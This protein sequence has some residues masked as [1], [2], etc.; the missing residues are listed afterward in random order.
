MV[1]KTR[2]RVI[3]QGSRFCCQCGTNLLQNGLHCQRLFLFRVGLAFPLHGLLMTACVEGEEGWSVW[4]SAGGLF[5]LAATWCCSNL[6]SASE[7]L[8]P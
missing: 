6:C 7:E 2:R 8:C 5:F 1:D 3:K 4:E